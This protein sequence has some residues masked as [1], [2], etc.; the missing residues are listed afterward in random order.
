MRERMEQHRANPVCASCHTRMDPLGF[1]LENFDAI[2]KWRTTEAGT[3]IDA[4]GTLPDGA[5]FDGPAE[6]RAMLAGRDSEFVTTVTSKLLTYALG[7]GV[8]YYDMPA[9]SSPFL[10]GTLRGS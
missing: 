1:A 3:P 10:V 5:S 9:E 2:G 8:E 4:S 7:R 6:L